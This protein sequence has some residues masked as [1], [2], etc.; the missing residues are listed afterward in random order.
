MHKNTLLFVAF[1]AV[2]AALLVGFNV[3]RSLSLSQ[4]PI[5][6]PTPD[7][8]PTPTLATLVGTSCGVTFQYP[9]TLTALSS[10]ASGVILTDTK[11]PEGSIVV[12]CQQEIPKVPL[13]PEN[14][15]SVTIQSATGTASV[16]AKLY[17]DASAKDGTPIDKLIFTH[18]NT[19]LDVFI[20][21]FGPVFQQ[22]I[23]SLKIL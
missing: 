9:N 21:G 23:A 8:T 14:I 12:V 10:T 19:G 1:L 15:E 16:S 13:S 2:I 18:P 7:I 17:H 22:L 4:V 5:P 20:A 6:S 3:G 11:N